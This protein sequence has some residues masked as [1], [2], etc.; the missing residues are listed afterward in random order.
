MRRGAL[1]AAASQKSKQGADQQQSGGN[2]GG[3]PSAL[4]MDRRHFGIRRQIVV[5]GSPRTMK[6]ACVPP[7]LVS[8][9]RRLR[10]LHAAALEFCNPFARGL[11]HFVKLAELDRLRGTRRRAGRLQS[12]FLP[13][14]AEGALEGAAIIRVASAPRRRDRTRRST[15]IHCRHPAEQTRRRIRCARSLPWDRLPGIRHSRSACRHRKKTPTKRVPA[16]LPPNPA[17]RRMLDE[18]HVPPGRMA[19]PLL[20][21]RRRSPLHSKP[22]SRDAVPFF[23]G[24]FAGF[25]A[26]AQRRVG[27]KCGDCSCELFRRSSRTWLLADRRAATPRPGCD[28]ADQRLGFHDAHVRLFRDRQQIVDDVAFHQC[29][30]SPSDKASPTW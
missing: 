21:C 18:L 28:V 9:G 16:A 10:V 7:T 23:A 5:R 17:T 26:D 25:A 20:C 27:E 8:A 6:T 30:C 13:V 1:I 15:R 11:A 3:C 24:D 29:P 12:H 14:V 2:A 19:Q 22:S 4:Q